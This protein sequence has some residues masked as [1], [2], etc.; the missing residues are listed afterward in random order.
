MPSP[1]VDIGW[2]L[3][4]QQRFRRMMKLMI[5]GK[6]RKRKGKKEKEK[7]KEVELDM[8]KEKEKE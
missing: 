3:G 5:A 6:K 7:E 1:C 4:N 8:E 2:V